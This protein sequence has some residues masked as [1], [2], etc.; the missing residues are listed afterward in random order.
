M[1]PVSE[2]EM[3]RI[4]CNEILQQKAL[5]KSGLPTVTQYPVLDERI[6]LCVIKD[7]W[8]NEIVAFRLE[9]VINKPL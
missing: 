2:A 7:L 1:Q 5:I 4:S 6:Y 3:Q 9:S 8:N